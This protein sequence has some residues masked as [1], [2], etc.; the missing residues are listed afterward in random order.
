M[1]KI[2]FDAKRAFHN[3]RGL[4][5]YS[6]NIVRLLT[7]YY[8][9]NEYFLFNPKKKGSI[10]LPANKHT[11][12]VNPESFFWKT[13]PAYW[14][15][16]G[17]KKQITAIGTN[18]YH[19]LSQE[20][21]IGIEKTGI[22]TVLTVHD[23]IFIRF[24]ELYDKFYIKIFTEKNR[25]SCRIADKII[26][27]S[28]QT[29]QDFI[30]FFDVQP[31]KIE[32]VYQGCD[33]IFRQKTTNATQKA[34]REKYNLPENFL[35]NVGA[36]EKRKN[37][38]TVIESIHCG[39][40]DLPLVAVGNRTAYTDE[41]ERLIEKYHLESKVILL[42]N[43]ASQ[44]LPALYTMAEIFIYPSVFEG[45]GI[46]VLEALCSGTPV[47]TSRGSCFAETGGK[48]SIYVDYNNAEEMAEAI[49]KILTNSN[50]R[51]KMIADGLL[52]AESFTDEKIA[53]NLMRVYQA[54]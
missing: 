33:N 11:R 4:G 47:I 14:R 19:G 42:H 13:L 43:V 35:L 36:M 40:T 2:S 23:A 3:N 24:P 28:E 18:I 39:K 50:L 8:P 51:Q 45:F 26:A 7:T 6:R 25:Y 21:P 31:E 49:D 12:E 30:N 46:P 22:R 52:Y 1:L 37:L 41:I 34:V 17:C 15:S 44:D 9:E 10:I 16:Y 54:P 53:A 5:V 29:R 20:L 48:S 38:A 32:V 27:V